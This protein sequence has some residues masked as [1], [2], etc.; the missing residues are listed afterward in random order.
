MENVTYFWSLFGEFESLV[1]L[2]S[3][4]TAIG[5]LSATSILSGDCLPKFEADYFILLV[6]DD[7][8][9]LFLVFTCKT[10]S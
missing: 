5:D 3:T 7:C 8:F 6:T 9:K 2:M 4:L 10:L 1:L